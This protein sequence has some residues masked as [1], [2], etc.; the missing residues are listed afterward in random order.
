MRRGVVSGLRDMATRFL[1]YVIEKQY[2]KIREKQYK[3]ENVTQI[4]VIVDLSGY[5]L[6]QHGCLN[7][8]TELYICAD[9]GHVT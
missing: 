7:C 9:I 4:Q 5:N 1:Y 6:V 2:K 8:K 3:G